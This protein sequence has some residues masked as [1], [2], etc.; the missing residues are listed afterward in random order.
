[1]KEQI[2]KLAVGVRDAL[3]SPAPQRPE[4]RAFFGYS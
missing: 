2:D 3:A 4:L 1:M